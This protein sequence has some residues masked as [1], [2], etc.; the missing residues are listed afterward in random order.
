MGRVVGLGQGWKWGWVGVSATAPSAVLVLMLFT[1]MVKT[2]SS[3]AGDPCR[4][5]L[6]YGTQM[7]MESYIRQSAL[8]GFMSICSWFLDLHREKVGQVEPQT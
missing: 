2:E 1:D 8:V 3:Q 6:L 7:A 4:E 5:V